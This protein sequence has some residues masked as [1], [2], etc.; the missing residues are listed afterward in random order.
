[1]GNGFPVSAIVMRREV[2]DILESRGLRYA[3]SHQND[4]L[5]CVVAQ[6]VIRIMQEENWVERG[7][8]LA[9]HFLQGLRNLSDKHKIIKDVRGRGMLLG[10]ELHPHKKITVET[11]YYALLEKGFLVG[12]YPAGNLLRFDPALTIDKDT[13]DQFLIVL[14]LVLEQTEFSL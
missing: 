14:D 12:Y 7:A 13:L 8:V 3:Q 9:A 10:L 5:G 4:P 1:L 2:A 11:L 6:E